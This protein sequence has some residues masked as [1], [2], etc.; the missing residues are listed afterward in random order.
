MRTIWLYIRFAVSQ[1]AKL[2][3]PA[4][5]VALVGIIVKLL[6]FVHVATGTLVGVCAAVGLVAT[7][8]KS[9]LAGLPAQVAAAKAPAPPAGK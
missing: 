1:L 3:N 4:S 5:D 9:A 2:S 7:W 6:P 8:A